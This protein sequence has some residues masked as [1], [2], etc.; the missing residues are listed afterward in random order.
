MQCDIAQALSKCD[1]ILKVFLS[2]VW[3]EAEV[4]KVT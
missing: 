1:S 3:I 4:F 2:A